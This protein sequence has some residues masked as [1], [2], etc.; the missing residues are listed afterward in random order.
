MTK[1]DKQK[2]DVI[3][4]LTQASVEGLAVEVAMN[5]LMPGS[6][7]A[8]KV[9]QGTKGIKKAAKIVGKQTAKEGVKMLDEN[10]EEDPLEEL[11]Q[12]VTLEFFNRVGGRG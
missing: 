5:A 10:K 4:K 12:D 9:L 11:S 1:T 7:V 2:S 8:T 3:Q 6:G